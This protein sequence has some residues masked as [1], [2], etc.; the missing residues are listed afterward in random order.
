MSSSIKDT[1][2]IRSPDAKVFDAL[3]SQAGYLGWWSKDCQIAQKPGEESRLKFIKDGNAV[4]MRFRLDQA[5]PGKS[6]RWTCVGH[7]MESWIGTTL[8]WNLAADGDV[9][10]VKFE[11]ADWK[12]EPPEPVWQGWRHFL[13]S[14]RSY[15][16]TGQG[17]P[18]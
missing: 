3:T 9:T 4:N 11:H 2:T 14:L 18:W 10:H 13:G 16:E 17:Q 5:V 8:R 15:V 7:D 1:L 6:V 12:G